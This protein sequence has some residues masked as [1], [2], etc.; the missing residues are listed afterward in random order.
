MAACGHEVGGLQNRLRGAA[1]ASWVGSIPIHPR[2]IWAAMTANMTATA[3]DV[4]A[5]WR[6]VADDVGVGY[7]NCVGAPRAVIQ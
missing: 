5:H 3:G 4:G 6:T 1:E 2:Q 7:T